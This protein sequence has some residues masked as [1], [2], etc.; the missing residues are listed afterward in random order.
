MIFKLP[1]PN[2]QIMYKIFITLREI[3]G[4]SYLKICTKYF[5]IEIKISNSWKKISPLISYKIDD[6]L[7]KPINYLM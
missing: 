1:K 4:W 6:T 2:K 3:L 7:Y 5:Q